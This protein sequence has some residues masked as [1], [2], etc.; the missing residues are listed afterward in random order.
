MIAFF[1]SQFGRMYLERYSRQGLQTNL[2]LDEVG[3][4]EIPIIDSTTQEHIA[5]Y[6][7][8]SFASKRESKALL[9]QAKQ[10]VE[11]AIESGIC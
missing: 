3:N 11:S 2:N 8:E 9:E 10:K 4:L 5:S 7:Q 1:N 6:I